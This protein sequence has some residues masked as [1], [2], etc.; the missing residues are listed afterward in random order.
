MRCDAVLNSTQ[1]LFK[2]DTL[3]HVVLQTLT[4]PPCDYKNWLLPCFFFLIT[5]DCKKE[6]RPSAG[7]WTCSTLQIHEVWRKYW[8]LYGTVKR[9]VII[10]NNKN[11]GSHLSH[12]HFLLFW[13]TLFHLQLHHHLSSSLTPS[14]FVLSCLFASPL[15]PFLYRNQ[16]EA[17]AYSTPFGS[18]FHQSCL[19]VFVR[20]SQPVQYKVNNVRH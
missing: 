12:L 17:S 14:V 18:S 10:K 9:G 19:I 11:H 20:L 15:A 1:K 3:L 6:L 8:I 2:L 16:K 13:D 5:I 7:G 4:N